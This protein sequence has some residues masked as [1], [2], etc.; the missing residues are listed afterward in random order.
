[1]CKE[2]LDP[3]P[4]SN[5]KCPHNLFWEKLKIDMR[6]IH[7]TEKAFQIRNCCRL[8]REPWTSDEIAE[9]WGLTKKKVKQCEK[10]AWRKIHRRSYDH[11]SSQTIS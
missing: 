9:V 8:I 6:R 4:C 3:N 7:M 10:S 1:M 5:C 11:E 2:K